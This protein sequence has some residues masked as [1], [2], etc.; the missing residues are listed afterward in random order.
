[1][2]KMHFGII[3][4]LVLF[5]TFSCKKEVT[6]SGQVIDAGTSLPVSGATVELGLLGDF[7][8]VNGN[9][10]IVGSPEGSYLLKITRDGYLSSSTEI[11]VGKKDQSNIKIPLQMDNLFLT[12]FQNEFTVTDSAGTESLIVLSNHS[13]TI[14]CDQSWVTFSEISGTGNDTIVIS[15]SKNLEIVSRVA[16]ISII[17]Q[18]KS[19][20][21]KISQ[22]ATPLI[23]SYA[24][25][26]ADYQI[27]VDYIKNHSTLS[28]YYHS[29]YGD[30]EY[31][32]GASVYYNNFDLALDVRRQQDPLGYLTY[33]NDVQAQELLFN[34]LNEA[35][36][37]II[38]DKFSNQTSYNG[39]QEVY[40][41]VTF[42][43]YDPS[44]TNNRHRTYKILC[45]CVDT[46]KF[47]CV[48]NPV[49][50]N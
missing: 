43:T 23:I 37:L 8:D 36:V 12:V 19:Q 16:N 11:V 21:V 35:I 41:E 3:L 18:N 9:F 47:E 39:E 10:E 6:I 17:G 31:Y 15:Y 46:G 13:W 40:Y 2:K 22:K 24:I 25:V 4:T 33:L 1:M 49:F 5:L 27:V 38:N 42:R 20:E 7:T 28:G 29:Y 32:Y 48:N 44:F 50:Q 14:E 45:K 30:Y 26:S 34:R